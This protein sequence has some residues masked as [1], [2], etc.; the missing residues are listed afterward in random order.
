MTTGTQVAENVPETCSHDM[1]NDTK[2]LS[3]VVGWA[4]G[5]DHDAGS[6]TGILDWVQGMWAWINEWAEHMVHVCSVQGHPITS[7]C[8]NFRTRL[9]RLVGL[10]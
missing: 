3:R 5:S 8:P 2:P 9:H 1:W 6:T 10:P 4:V 7:G